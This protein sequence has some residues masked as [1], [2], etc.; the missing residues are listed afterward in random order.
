MPRPRKKTDFKKSATRHVARKKRPTFKR[1][2]KKTRMATPRKAE[3]VTTEPFL[4][5]TKPVGVSRAKRT[6]QPTPVRARFTDPLRRFNEFENLRGL[7]EAQAQLLG[8]RTFM[9][10][11][12]DGREYSYTRLNE[13]TNRAANMLREIGLVDGNRVALLMPNSPEYVFMLL[14]AMKAGLIVVPLHTD[15]EPDQARTQLEDSGAAALVIDESLWT[16]VAGYSTELPGLRAILLAGGADAPDAPAMRADHKGL[17]KAA[18]V[19]V[20]SLEGALEAA[21]PDAVEQRQPRWWDEAAI[22]YT[23]HDLK[24][25]RGAILQHRQFLTAARWLSVWLKLT[26]KDRFL[27]ALPLF[28]AN[29]QVL[30]IFTPLLM[31]ATVVLSRE[32]NVA[33]TW[34]AVERY[35]ATTMVAVP[36]MLGILA[37]R[38]L[39]EAR[40]ARGEAPW[41]TPQ[42]SPGAL[43]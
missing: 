42:E 10:F 11:E 35:K 34:H 19:P 8:E 36:T 33:R 38:E 29:A 20:I 30:G 15:L 26:P 21:N 25:P 5:T 1:S 22:M 14:G 3:E 16:K 9:I 41:P 4:K 13:R 32:F 31:G 17:G 23:G 6:G 12:D 7:I 40:G 37:S 28:H 18:D 43:G 24:N 2:A 39:N 27:N